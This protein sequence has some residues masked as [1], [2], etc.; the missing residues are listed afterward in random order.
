MR[1]TLPQMLEDSR[2]VGGAAYASEPG[3]TYGAFLIE[4]P[5]HR[6]LKILSSGTDHT[7]GWEHVSVSTQTGPPS[8]DEMCFVKGLFWMDEECVMQLHPPKSQYVNDHPYVL[9]LWRPLRA[10]IPMPKKIQV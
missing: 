1:K 7:Y 8:W 4:R 2:V 6:T 9:H 5:G 10:H 3:K